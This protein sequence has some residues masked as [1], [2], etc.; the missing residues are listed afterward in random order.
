MAALILAACGLA[1]CDGADKPTAGGAAPGAGR[2]SPGGSVAATSAGQ[3]GS[4]VPGPVPVSVLRL[5]RA[6]LS[7]FGDARQI[8]SAAGASTSVVL[9]PLPQNDGLAKRYGAADFPV[10][11][12]QCR[13]WVAGLWSTAVHTAGLSNTSAAAITSLYGAYSAQGAHSS[14]VSSVSLMEITE[15]IMAVP[16]QADAVRLN[17][18][19][20]P[21]RCQHTQI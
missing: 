19:L 17:A 3:P 2:S 7:Q 4:Q 15:I 16:G 20:V 10:R 11:D 9:A 1:A 21:A 14:S 5:E 13:P 8:S 18:G 6:L 12:P